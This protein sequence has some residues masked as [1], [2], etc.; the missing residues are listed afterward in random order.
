LLTELEPAIVDEFCRAM[1]DV[2]SGEATASE[3]GGHRAIAI[4]KRGVTL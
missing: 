1:L 4:W 2:A 3:R